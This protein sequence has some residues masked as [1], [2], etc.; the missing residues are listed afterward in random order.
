MFEVKVYQERRKKLKETLGSGILLF[1]GNEESPMN[2]FDNVYH[3][4][5]DSTFL[6]FWGMDYPSLGAV[7]DLDED[8]E[9]LF[10]DELSIDMIVWMGT[11]PTLKERAGK[12]GINEVMSYSS[13][14]EYLAKNKKRKIHFLPPYRYENKIKLHQM[15]DLPIEKIEENKSVEF[16]KAV[17]AQREI[18]SAEEIVELD[19][20]VS[21]SA[22]MHI[23]AMK[24][25]RPGMKE[26]EVAARIQEVG[27]AAGGQLSFPIIC[28]INGQTLHNHYHGNIIGE[29]DLLLID[30][31][32]ETD[33][34][35]AGD[36]SHTFPIKSKFTTRQKEIY[37]IALNA[38]NAAIEMLRPGNKMLDVHFTAA[39][40]IVKGMKDLGLMKGDPEEAVRQGAHALFFQCGT[41]HMMG[42]DVHDMEN[43]GEQYVG[44]DETTKK[45]TQL[46]GLKS[47]RLGKELKPGFVLTIEPGIYFI[48]E[49]IDMWKAENRF[50]DFV[51]YDQVEKYK[52]WG[53]CRSEE[54]FL[55]TENGK[56]LLGKDVPKTIEDIEEIRSNI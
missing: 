18:K 20:A 47:L 21:I 7:I 40:T 53:G 25:A 51:N 1:L 32:A 24:M 4:R 14:H 27:V 11:Q 56:R 8:K 45:E 33:T 52:G 2:Y 5:Q 15:L 19:K 6:Y 12:A 42:L 34:H 16:I 49:L 44:Y 41:G 23:A 31:G 35:Y 9:I 13:L 43:L 39:K 22:D 36:L 50:A 26:S 3:F 55:I 37:Q 29:N 30:A 46:F 17:V 54:D 48:P 28:T 10:G 38:H